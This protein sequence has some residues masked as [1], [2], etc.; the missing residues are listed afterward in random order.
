MGRGR[1]NFVRQEYIGC[2]LENGRGPFRTKVR[3]W[4]LYMS[5][6]GVYTFKILIKERRKY[7][8][9]FHR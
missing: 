5:S 6:S 4:T 9:N 1:G 8:E 2:T 3:S 7:E